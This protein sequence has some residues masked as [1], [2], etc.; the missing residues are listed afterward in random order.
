MRKEPGKDWKEEYSRLRKHR[1]PRSWG[2]KEPGNLE[3]R[4]EDQGGQHN[5]QGRR[6]TRHEVEGTSRNHITEAMRSCLHFMLFTVEDSQRAREATGTGCLVENRQAWG[7]CQEKRRDR[8]LAEKADVAQMRVPPC[9][10][11]DYLCPWMASLPLGPERRL[12][13]PDPPHLAEHTLPQM[14]LRG[15][16]GQEET[17]LGTQGRCSARRAPGSLFPTRRPRHHT[18]TRA[19]GL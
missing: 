16:A 9:A 17:A 3:K 11:R 1:V 14:L 7:W 5:K 4:K 10:W 18:G 12:N 19:R 8:K 6:V 15:E 2:M 13:G